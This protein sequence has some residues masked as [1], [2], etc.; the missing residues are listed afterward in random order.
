[1]SQ[2]QRTQEQK[3]PKETKELVKALHRKTNYQSERI[4]ELEETVR[5][6]REQL[7]EEKR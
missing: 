2:A 6:L 1:M 5:D 3:L 4:D 7:R